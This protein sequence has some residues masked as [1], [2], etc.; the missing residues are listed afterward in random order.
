MFIVLFHIFFKNMQVFNQVF[1]FLFNYLIII[2]L[3]FISNGLESHLDKKKTKKKLNHHK[4]IDKGMK[5]KQNV[6][7]FSYNIRFF[8]TY[9]Q[10]E[11]LPR[12]R[13]HMSKYI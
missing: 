12:I 10:G 4:R 13:K 2:I 9:N 3:C 6:P 5:D 7:T 1:N 8:T 11:K